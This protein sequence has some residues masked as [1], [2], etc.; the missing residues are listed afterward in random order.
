MPLMLIHRLKLV[1]F[2]IG[3]ALWFSLPEVVLATGGALMG[4]RFAGEPLWMGLVG[5][6]AV[7]LWVPLMRARH[8]LELEAH[9][10]EIARDI[11]EEFP[12]SDIPGYIAK[13]FGGR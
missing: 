9:A 5:V 1:A 6:L 10:R 4:A 12:P 7:L 2:W 13:E 3:F 8:R 11:A